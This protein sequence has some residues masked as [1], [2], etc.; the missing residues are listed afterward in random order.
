METSEIVA[1]Y[2]SAWNEPDEAKRTAILEESWADDGVYQDPQGTVEGRA[3]LVAHIGGF[4]AAYPGCTIEQASGVESNG[5]GIRWAWEMRNGDAIEIDGMDFAELALDGRIPAN[6]RILRAAPAARRLSALR[7]RHS[8]AMPAA[9]GDGKRQRRLSTS[10]R[11][12]SATVRGR[13]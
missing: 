9:P 11:R 10:Q 8:R 6:R 7:R 1:T 4:H 3:A 2:N 13:L 5:V 12:R